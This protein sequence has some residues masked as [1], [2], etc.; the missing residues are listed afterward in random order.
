MHIPKCGC[1]ELMERLWQVGGRGGRGGR[2]EGGRG[3]VW[4]PRQGP[5]PGEKAAAPVSAPGMMYVLQ[6]VQQCMVPMLWESAASSRGHRRHTLSTAV[7]WHGKCQLSP[8]CWAHSA[9]MTQADRQ[10]NGC[11]C[12]GYKQN[13][14]DA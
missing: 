2:Q 8:S 3:Q 10:G 14:L 12:T 11:M 4:R 1:S 7:C 5:G 9:S 13:T 6:A